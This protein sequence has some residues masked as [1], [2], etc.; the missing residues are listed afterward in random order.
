[1]ARYRADLIETAWEVENIYGTAPT[2]VDKGFGLLTGGI[3]LPDPRYEWEPFYGIGVDDRNLLTYVQGRQVFEGSFPS[4]YL[5]HDNSRLLLEQSLGLIFNNS[6]AI[7]AASG[8][9]VPTT[10]QI[11]MTGVGAKGVTAGADPTHI[12]VIA[13]TNTAPDPFKDTWAYIGAQTTNANTARVHHSRNT[14][15]TAD[16]GWQGKLPSGTVQGAV[17][18]INRAPATGSGTSAA[19]VEAPAAVNVT[20]NIGIRETLKQNSFT[21]ASKISA[22]NGQ[23]FITNFLGCKMGG[24]SLT[25]EEGRPVT[26]SMDF[27]AQDM[28]H[29]MPDGAVE[30]VLKYAAS[31]KAPA[32]VT[33]TEQP[34]FFSR[35]NIKFGGTIFAKIRRLT[36]TIANALDPRY[37]VTQSGATADNR[38]ILTEILEGR[39]TVTVSGSIDMDDTA[40][41]VGAGMSNGP[42][43]KMLQYLF[44]QGF[45]DTDVR[46]QAV[47]AGISLEVELRRNASTTADSDDTMTFT[48]PGKDTSVSASNPGLVFNSARFPIPGPSQVH[49]NI[50]F[51]AVARGMRIA[52]RDSV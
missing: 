31:P 3:T 5:C 13:Q 26:A 17:Y 38:Q 36:L 50:E 51:D 12:I 24:L 44:N 32:M 7:A 25:M 8:N 49:Q 39:R 42:D 35:A 52:I 43:I 14:L 16:I 45:T 19:G 33:V 1:M 10:V 11:G 46:D 40:A 47:L 22:D 41:G 28:N 34:Y 15:A 30:N 29:N 27:T 18:S 2:T 20:T 6:A 4:I 48:L 9:A 23:S 37:Y 21:L